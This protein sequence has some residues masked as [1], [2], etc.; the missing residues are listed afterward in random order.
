MLLL[1][2]DFRVSL[3]THSIDNT[4]TVEPWNK[5]KK[6]LFQ[7]CGVRF[8]IGVNFRAGVGVGSH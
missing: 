3:L 1:I 8:R 7:G 6:H 5:T 4:E 2:D